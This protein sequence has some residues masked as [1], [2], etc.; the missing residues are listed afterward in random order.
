MNST[1]EKAYEQYVKLAFRLMLAELVSVTIA[2]AVAVF[3]AA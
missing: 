1:E 2:I 3:C